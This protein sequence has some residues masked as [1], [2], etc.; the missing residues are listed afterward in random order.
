MTRKTPIAIF[1]YNRPIHLRQL[2]DSLLNCARLNECDI[3]I[4]CDGPRK[5]EHEQGVKAALE[6]TRE[7]APRLNNAHVLERQQNMGLA[8]S[9]V[10]GVTE[11]CSQYGSVIVLEDDFILHPFILDFMLQALD[12]YAQDERVAQVAGFTFPIKVPKK[13]DAFLLPLTTSWGWATWQRAWE[14]FSWDARLALDTLNTDHQLKA[15]FDLDGAYTYADMLRLTAEGRLDSWAIRWYWQT[16][17]ANKLTLYPRRS[18]VWQNGFDESA[19]HTTAPWRKIQTPLKG[20]M[21]TQWQNPISFP[22]MVQTN[23]LAFE[24]LKR[25]LQR[26]SPRARIARLKEGLKRV[27]RRLAI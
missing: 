4:Y 26:G 9:I 3:Y 23:E 5:P 7:F 1:T 24:D 8:R 2:L 18:L 15:R 11:L 17:A 19:T 12:R 16:F 27:L 13:P 25:F 21:Q 20:F 22:N 10:S 14:L 6:V